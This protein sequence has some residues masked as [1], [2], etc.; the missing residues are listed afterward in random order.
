MRRAP[1]LRALLTLLILVASSASAFAEFQYASVVT[2]ENLDVDGNGTPNVIRTGALANLQGAP[3]GT[4]VSYAFSADTGQVTVGFQFAS[5]VA[6]PGLVFYGISG[7]G[8]T[9]VTIAVIR[10]STDYVSNPTDPT[11]TG[12]GIAL[13]TS[14]TDF[15]VSTSGGAYNNGGFNPAAGYTAVFVQFVLTPGSTLTLD[16]ISN[17]EPGTLA[18]FG[19]G[20]LGLGGFAWKRRTLRRAAGRAGTTRV[21]A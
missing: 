4:T 6:A 18:L 12:L 9:G 2:F 11:A 16:A 13:P 21:A 17:P 14:S 7:T 8:G 1:F 15:A 19:L 3:D 5:A 20:V 10:W